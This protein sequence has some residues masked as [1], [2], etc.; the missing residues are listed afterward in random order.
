M[1]LKSLNE[2]GMGMIEVVIAAGLM[3]VLVLGMASMYETQQKQIKVLMQKQE[4]V[5]LKNQMLTNLNNPTVCTWQ[6][7]DKAIDVSMPTSE[8]SPSPTILTLTNNTIYGGPNSTSAP[9]A[10]AGQKLPNS[11]HGLQVLRVAFKGIFATGNPDEY[12]GVFEV[13]LDP[14]STPMPV[15]PVQVPVTIST[16]PADPPN[17]KKIVSC[18]GEAPGSLRVEGQA[19]VGGSTCH[20]FLMVAVPFALR[21]LPNGSISQRRL[22]QCPK[23]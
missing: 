13:V 16:A 20:R 5:D 21:L 12:R 7:K 8:V 11:I 18:R 15:R 22:P 6:L 23:F 17:A 9:L 1:C 19:N 10:S 4:L 3:G 2:R 14:A